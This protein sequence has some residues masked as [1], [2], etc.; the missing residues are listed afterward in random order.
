MSYRI[1]ERF[2]QLLGDEKDNLYHLC[3]QPQI[4]C[5]FQKSGGEGSAAVPPP[6]RGEESPQK[7]E[8]D[9]S[10]LLFGE[11]V[12]ERGKSGF[13]APGERVR[14]RGKGPFAGKPTAPA[15]QTVSSSPR[16]R[17]F[18]SPAAVAWRGLPVRREAE[19]RAPAGRASSSPVEPSPP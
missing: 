10:P 12:R 16:Q 18:R 7:C 14:V 3:Y 19:H 6:S 9:R 1:P 8:H 17:R 5:N 15:P 2:T 13:L 4:L 11:R